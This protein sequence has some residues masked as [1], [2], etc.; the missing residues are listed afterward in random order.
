M[1]AD[2][3]SGQSILELLLMLPMMVGLV[4][5]T[6]RIDMAIQVSINNQQYARAQ[7]LFLT[8]NSPIYPERKENR[9]RQLSGVNRMVIGVSDNTPSSSEGDNY[10]PAAT[11]VRVTRKPSSDHGPTQEEP[12]ERAFV[13]IR[14]TVSLCTQSNMIQGAS[15][16]IE[17][18][19]D[20]LVEGFTPSSYDYCKGALQ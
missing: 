18:K 9:A 4:I 17:L 20:T 5:L 19:P 8:F 1:V 16:L 13:R 14:D 3:E 6:Y 10:Q 2:D 15:G 7:A 12:D 11:E